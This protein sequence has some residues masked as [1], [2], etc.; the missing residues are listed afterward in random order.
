MS[1]ERA[2]PSSD[3]RIRHDPRYDHALRARVAALRRDGLSV[4]AIAVRVNRSPSR[5]YQ[6]LCELGLSKGD[7]A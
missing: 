2:A 4:R 6:L 1:H 7:A 5:V 3:P